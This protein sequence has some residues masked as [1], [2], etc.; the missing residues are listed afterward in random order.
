MI[1]TIIEFL[2]LI[3]VGGIVWYLLDKLLMMIIGFFEGMFPTYYLEAEVVF[4]KSICHWFL[5]FLVFG[6]LYQ[7][8]VKSQR[9]PTPEGYYT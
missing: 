1:N 5:L 9:K 4:L 6:G 3:G 7:L 8:W 2:S